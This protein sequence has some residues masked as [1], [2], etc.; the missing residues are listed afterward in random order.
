MF[1]GTIFATDQLKLNFQ[2][3]SQHVSFCQVN[4]AIKL[5]L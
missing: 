1:H 5:H 4:T 2:K 3:W